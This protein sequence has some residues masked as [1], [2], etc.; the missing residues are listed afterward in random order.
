[1]VEVGGHA[2]AGHTRAFAAD[3]REVLRAYRQFS[4]YMHKDRES[5]AW[6]HIPYI[7]VE[8]NVMKG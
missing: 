1:M 5:I 3:E 4:E 8:A 6:T 2:L 7:R